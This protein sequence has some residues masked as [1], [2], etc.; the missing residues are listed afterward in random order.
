MATLKASEQLRWHICQ[1]FIPFSFFLI[2]HKICLHFFYT[3]VQKSQND[4]KLTSRKKTNCKSCS[5]GMTRSTCDFSVRVVLQR[6]KSKLPYLACYS[7]ALDLST[8][9]WHGAFVHLSPSLGH[10]GGLKFFHQAL[11]W[12]DFTELSAVAFLNLRKSSK[13]SFTSVNNNR[14]AKSATP[15][16]TEDERRM[17]Q[18]SCILFFYYTFFHCSSDWTT[19]LTCNHKIKRRENTQIVVQWKREKKTFKSHTVQPPNMQ[20][21]LQKWH[22][23]KEAWS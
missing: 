18:F 15:R 17:V 9:A 2:S 13:K 8:L 6:T 16:H 3:M 5:S 4:Q 12:Q 14:P 20:R 1:T 11:Q 10:P 22:S 21:L 23:S 19:L 7:A